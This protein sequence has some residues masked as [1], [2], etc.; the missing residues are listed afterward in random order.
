MRFRFVVMMARANSFTY[1]GIT[2]DARDLS[3]D[4]IRSTTL[5]IFKRFGV[6]PEGL[7][8]KIEARGVAPNGGGEV[9]LT[10]P[11]VRM[12]TVCNFFRFLFFC[13]FF[14][15]FFLAASF[16]G[17]FLSVTL[18]LLQA[19]DWLDEGMVKR[20]RGETFSAKVSTDF[21]HSMRFAAR[22]IFNNLLPDVHIFQNHNTGLQAGK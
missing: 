8:L 7:E 21:E 5:H 15:C 20:I 3:V 4:T 6:P 1:A 16:I 17:G 11:N 2:N 10:V 14:F 22:G 19:V 18:L 9:L 13:F 12:L